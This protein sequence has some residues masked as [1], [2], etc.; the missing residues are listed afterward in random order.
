MAYHDGELAGTWPRRIEKHILSCAG[1]KQTLKGLEAVDQT[2]AMPEPESEYWSGFTAR[3][4]DRVKDESFGDPVQI[5]APKPKRSYRVMRL[6]PAFSIALVVVVAAGLLMEIRGPVVPRQSVPIVQKQAVE[7]DSKA[8]RARPEE[9]VKTDRVE[10]HVQAE[11]KERVLTDDDIQLAEPESAAVQA[12]MAEP[13]PAVGAVSVLEEAER[14]NEATM[15]AKPEPEISS[16]G[17]DVYRTYHE[18]YE[19]STL[20]KRESFS[21]DDRYDEEPLRELMLKAETLSHEGRQAESEKVL[22]DLLSQ[23]PPSPFQERATMLLVRVLQYQD[24]I[25]E[26]RQLLTD[27]QAAYPKND[28]V[29]GFSLETAPADLKPAQ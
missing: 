15:M 21:K 10:M 8:N 16:G 24:R 12:P 29:Q 28:M 13:A 20:R 18:D 26:A 11:E 25:G 23:S 5:K 9:T 27:A 7:A 2:I 4:M 3:I 6:A 19:G 17:A 22:R 1:C 14:V